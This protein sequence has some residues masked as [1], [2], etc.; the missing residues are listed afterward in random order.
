MNLIVASLS[1]RGIGNY[2]EW[3]TSVLLKISKVY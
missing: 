2:D 3:K 1:V